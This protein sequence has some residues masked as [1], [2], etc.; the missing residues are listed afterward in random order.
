MEKNNWNKQRKTN[1]AEDDQ[2]AVAQEHRHSSRG[3]RAKT[4][5]T[6]IPQRRMMWG[7]ETRFSKAATSLMRD[8]EKRDDAEDNQRTTVD[9]LQMNKQRTRVAGRRCCVHSLTF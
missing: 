2:N 7:K 9:G 8:T 1:A 5:Q 4:R 6:V 3:R